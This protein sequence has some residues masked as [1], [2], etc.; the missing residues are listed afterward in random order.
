MS[1][2]IHEIASLSQQSQQATAKSHYPS[3]RGHAVMLLT[4]PDVTLPYPLYQQQSK[5]QNARGLDSINRVC[6]YI[7]IY[8][9]KDLK[10]DPDS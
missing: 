3:T 5:E 9:Y 10:S 6:V 1:C 7:Y 8:I 2:I 4:T